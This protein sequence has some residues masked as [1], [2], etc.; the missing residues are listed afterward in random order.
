MI[1]VVVIPAD[2]PGLVDVHE[3]DGESSYD[4]TIGQ[5][6]Q[7]VGERGWVPADGGT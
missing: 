7:L 1:R 3:V 6:R 2:I 5:F 4:L